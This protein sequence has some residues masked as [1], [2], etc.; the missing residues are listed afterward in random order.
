[1]PDEDR[2]AK[3][4]SLVPEIYYDLIARVP[5]G[6]FLVI[7]AMR[8]QGAFSAGKA[9]DLG[10]IKWE[11]AAI[12][13]IFLLITGYVAGVVITAVA[14]SLSLLYKGW[15][16]KRSAVPY[17]EVIENFVDNKFHLG[18]N[19][20][21]WKNLDGDDFYRIHRQVQDYLESENDQAKL[22]L[23]KMR[24]ESALCDNLLASL[25]LLFC[26]VLFRKASGQNLEGWIGS[27]T[28]IFLSSC[29]VFWA[30]CYRAAQ[31]IRRQ[32]SFLRIVMSRLEVS[33]A[34]AQEIT[35]NN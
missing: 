5:P 13:L 16:W 4:A 25:A 20:K 7:A 21:G 22:I 3:W 26:F 14:H 27:L 29:L 30:A 24:A 19:I 10:N 9:F 31:L 11:T 17:K 8:I 18:L 32:F 33:K 35:T 6:A 15:V 34:L 12:L 2:I 28:I 23:P 1:M